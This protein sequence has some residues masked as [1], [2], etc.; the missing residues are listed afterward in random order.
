MLFPG[1]LINEVEETIRLFADDKGSQKKLKMIEIIGKFPEKKPLWNSV[2]D[3]LKA[4]DLHRENQL[5][6]HRIKTVVEQ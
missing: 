4:E 1:V 2:R 6:K 5:C 3:K